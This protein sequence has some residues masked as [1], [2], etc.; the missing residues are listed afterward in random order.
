MAAPEL[1]GG[2]EEGPFMWTFIFLG[3]PNNTIFTFGISGVNCALL[4][5]TR[6]LHYQYVVF[7]KYVFHFAVT[8]LCKLEYGLYS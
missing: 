5:L 8:V 4:S 7:G 3:I 1:Y 2:L 6:F